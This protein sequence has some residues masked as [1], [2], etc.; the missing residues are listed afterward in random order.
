MSLLAEIEELGITAVQLMELSDSELIRI[1]KKLKME[2]RMN[3]RIDRNLIDRVLAVLKENR[4]EL[5]RLYQTQYD[6]LRKV[7]T[8]PTKFWV[9]KVDQAPEYDPEFAQFL[10]R[11]FKDELQ[12]YLDACLEDEHYKALHAVLQYH[13]IIGFELTQPLV[14]KMKQKMVFM[15]ESV[16]MKSASLEAKLTPGMNP[17]FYRCLNRL[18]GIQFE[19]EFRDLLNFSVDHLS[20]RK[21]KLRML[22]SMGAYQSV[23]DQMREVIRQNREAA[24]SYGVVENFSNSGGNNNRGGTSVSSGFGR[25]SSS[26]SSGGWGGIGAAGFILYVIIKIAL[27]VSRSSSNDRVHDFDMPNFYQQ[28]PQLQQ[29]PQSKKADEDFFDLM[30]YLHGDEVKIEQNVSIPFSKEAA[31]QEEDPIYEAIYGATDNV[32]ITNLSTFNVVAHFQ[33]NE[34]YHGR[35]FFLEPGEKC[36]VQSTTKGARF[37]T[38]EDFE[39]VTYIDKLG[40]TNAHFRFNTFSYADIIRFEYYHS[41]PQDMER[42][43][44]Y[45]GY[46]EETNGSLDLLIEENKED[47][48]Y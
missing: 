38:G 14:G 43:L 42:I 35:I 26:K 32:S 23:N 7:L 46:I 44:N 11:Y 28:F 13:S 29:V 8:T 2:M 24:S 30:M 12:A 3:D 16:R 41:F 22:F 19:S 39:L 21:L 37:Y 45:D 33:T 27:V 48:T 5:Q 6:G 9:F 15:T 36:S 20:D 34:S 1:E 18:G 25:R 40:Q 4:I 47:G 17:F 10:T 31:L